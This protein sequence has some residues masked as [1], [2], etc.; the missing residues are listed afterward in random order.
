MQFQT[1]PYI[2]GYSLLPSNP[3]VERLSEFI[4]SVINALGS[5]PHPNPPTFPFH[6]EAWH[7]P[8]DEIVLCEIASRGG[9]FDDNISEFL[10][11]D[12]Y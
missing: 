4:E 1:N 2:A 12:S 8:D 6:A 9:T 11:I 5:D 10:P 3:L 7:T